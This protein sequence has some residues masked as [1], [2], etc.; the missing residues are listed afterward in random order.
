MIRCFASGLLCGLA[1]VFSGCSSIGGGKPAGQAQVI[2]SGVIESQIQEK[3]EVV[4]DR[5]GFDYKGATAGRMEFERAGGTMDN[6]LYG[7]WQKK[8][9]TTN[10]TLFITPAGP[11]SYALR[12]RSIAVRNTFGAD[13]DTKL[14][15]IQGA[16]YKVILD[17]IAKELREENPQ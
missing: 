2:V 4:F 1:L 9:I 11:T 6:L 14:F 10:V 8:D 16:K 17:K 5:H 3:A 15:D 13:S 7:N 12:I